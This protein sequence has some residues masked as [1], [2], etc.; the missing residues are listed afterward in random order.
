MTDA[1]VRGGETA[2]RQGSK[3]FSAASRLFGRSMREDAW[4]LY[5]WCRHCDDVVDGQVAGFAAPGAPQAS[6]Q[7]RL[8]LLFDQ[9]RRALSGAP[10]QNP[11]FTGFARVAARHRIPQRYPLELL[12]GFAMDV[13]GARYRSLDD[14]L[15]YSYH[16]AGVV[17]IMMAL[18]MG[19]PP[20]DGKTLDRACD[21][22][23]GFQLTNIARDVLD[24]A[25]IGRVYLPEDWLAEAGIPPGQVAAPAH[26]AALAGVVARLLDAAEPYY[27]SAGIGLAALPRRAAW[28]VAT[29]RGVYREIGIRLRAQGAAGWDRRVVV[30]GHRKLWHIGAGGMAAVT[31]ARA[32]APRP[33]ELWRRP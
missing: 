9:T 23:L 1:V 16:V 8:E 28:A 26:R 5:A 32:E 4:M 33:P 30:P 27:A 11:V 31:A 19:V 12:Q 6:P 2:I 22:G 15:R 3:S 25:A 18:V 29:A 21:L 13:E 20:E 7:E 10:V 17:G 14:T 24:D